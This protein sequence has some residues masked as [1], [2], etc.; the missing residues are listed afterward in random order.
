MQYTHCTLKWHSRPIMLQLRNNML[1]RQKYKIIFTFW[2][3]IL[4]LCIKF[5]LFVSVLHLWFLR[6]ILD[7]RN[8]LQQGK[9]HFCCSLIIITLI[10]GVSNT[11]S[12]VS[13]TGQPTLGRW[14]LQEHL[15]YSHQLVIFSSTCLNR[16]VYTSYHT[17][18][19]VWP[20]LHFNTGK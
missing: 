11:N 3:H 14:A 12:T 9:C 6:I 15:S 4:F 16:C 8:Y 17:H 10:C 13:Y 7:R 20:K 2:F 19:M 1:L 5:C 18:V